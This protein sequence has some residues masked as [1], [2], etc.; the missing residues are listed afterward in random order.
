[1]TDPFAAVGK[2][3]GVSKSLM[4]IAQRIKNAELLNLIADLNGALADAKMEI[5]DLRQENHALRQEVDGLRGSKIQEDR[6]EIKGG[7]YFIKN[8]VDGE[9]AGP[10]CAACFAKTGKL[11]P[12]K[13]LFQEYAS[14]AKWEC[15]SCQDRVR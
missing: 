2:A 8:P 7:K 15:P 5:V 13:T 4:E 6:L 1:M 14:S 3:I 12:H 10:F 11:I 9:Y